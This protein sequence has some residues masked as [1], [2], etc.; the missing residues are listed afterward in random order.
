MKLGPALLTVHLWLV[1][2]F[3]YV[4]IVVMALML[5]VSF[6]KHFVMA[7]ADPKFG[8]MFEGDHRSGIAL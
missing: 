2:V 4:P 7:A 5:A 3:L 1:L 8:R 6:G